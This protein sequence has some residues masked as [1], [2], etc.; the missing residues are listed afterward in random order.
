MPADQNM[1]PQCKK[2]KLIWQSST[3]HLRLSFVQWTTECKAEQIKTKAPA[4]Y[5]ISKNQEQNGYVI[6]GLQEKKEAMLSGLMHVNLHHPKND[7]AG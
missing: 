5:Y 1:N 6:S 7:S 2:K 4:T 3:D